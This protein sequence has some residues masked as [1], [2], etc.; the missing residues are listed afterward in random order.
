MEIIEWSSGQ[1]QPAGNF[2]AALGT[3]DGVHRGHRTII[4]LARVAAVRQGGQSMVITFDPHP[5]TVTNPDTGQ[6]LLTSFPE[7]A[8]I[9]AGLGIDTLV[10]I[11]FSPAIA[12][13]S[14]EAFV[15]GILARDLGLRFVAVGFN[16]RFGN[17]GRGDARRLQILCRKEGITAVVGDP[18]LVAGQVVSST[19]IRNALQAGEVG[20]AAEF[21]GYY[22]RLGG[23][24]VHGDRRGRTLGYPTANIA[25]DPALVRPAAGVYA[26]MVDHRGVRY[27]GVANL[28]YRP[29]FHGLDESEL[30]L[31]VVIFAFSGE[32]YGDSLTLEF[33]ARLRPERSFPS[34]SELMAQIDR[35]QAEAREILQLLPR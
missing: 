20:M 16:Y 22:P 14:P 28:G 15:K 5:R 7:K 2:Y 35:D 17:L 23:I 11:P 9:M 33:I 19:V 21:L 10:K 4:D 25:V 24:V 29:T 31:E 34:Q 32:I 13:L 6:S 1:T 27:G 3:F 18:V 8:A 26:V 12:A 30:R